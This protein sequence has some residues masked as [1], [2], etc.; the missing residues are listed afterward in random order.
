MAYQAYWLLKEPVDL[1]NGDFEKVESIHQGL[2]QALGGDSGTQDIS[3]ILR[4]PG[5]YNVKI[6]DEPKHVT[7]TMVRPRLGL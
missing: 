3:R 1:R 2:S 7:I 4:I 6:P 5:T